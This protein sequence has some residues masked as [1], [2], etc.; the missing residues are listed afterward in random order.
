VSLQGVGHVGAHLCD[1]LHGAGARLIVADIDRERAT[2]LSGMLGCEC[3]APEDILTV[4]ADIFAPCAL[5]AV[6]N[7]RTIPQLQVGA[8]VGG[9][10]NQLATPEDGRRLHE[11]G[12]L[13]APD[14]VVNAGGV[15]NVSAEVLRIEDRQ[16][17]VEQKLAALEVSL[18][19][20]LTRAAKLDRSPNDVAE[21]TVALA[22]ART[23][24]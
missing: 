23:A 14:F 17:W 6:L 9:A 1:L 15:I 13:F 5:G 16:T 24:A 20:I 11:R 4:H 19:A 3:V 18:D 7:A 22:L 2:G 10:N 12:V 21:E 8:V